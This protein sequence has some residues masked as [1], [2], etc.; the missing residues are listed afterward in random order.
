MSEKELRFVRSQYAGKMTMVDTWF[1]HLMAELDR[2]DLWN[3][4]MVIVTTDH[5]HDLGERKA[6]GKA[7]RTTTAMPTF[8][9]SCGI[10]P[11]P[12]RRARSRG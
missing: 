8:R 7:I 6:F 5:G 11:L 1:G 9:C 10:P 3:D 2:Q 12:T 4:T